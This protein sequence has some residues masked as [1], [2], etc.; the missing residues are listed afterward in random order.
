[1][2]LKAIVEEVPENMN[3][4]Y[5][6]GEGANEGKFV[7][8]VESVGG[9][10][11]EDVGG[12]KKTMEDW[13]GKANTSRASLEAF[14]EYTPESIAELAT[15]AQS[16]GKPS[17][18]LESLKAEYGQKLTASQSTIEQ[19]Q[20]TI[21]KNAKSNTINN[22]FASNAT[23]FQDGSSDLVKQIMSNYIGTDDQGNAFIF[24]D[25]KT[26]SRMSSKQGAWEQQM[27]T[28]E[29]LEGVKGAITSNGKFDGIKANDL[30][31]MGFLLASN[32][33]AGSGASSP[34]APKAGV[35]TSEKWAKMSLT[36]RT[37]HV[38]DGGNIPE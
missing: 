19:L 7:L 20:E 29:W 17:E 26:G 10:G 15:K 34:S 36:E 6:E 30:K 1:M 23:S 14:G 8:S 18:A 31:S 13:K 2:S 25:D 4:F 28:A 22:I 32:A 38:K 3:D 9:F 16:A 37:K 11:L 5:V 27:S 24:N 33:K 21:K 12:L 35:M